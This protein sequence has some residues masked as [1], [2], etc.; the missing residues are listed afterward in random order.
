MK[1]HLMVEKKHAKKIL[2]YSHDFI[3]NYTHV[4]ISSCLHLLL[5][6]LCTELLWSFIKRAS[7]KVFHYLLARFIRRGYSRS[8]R[9]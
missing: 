8:H 4:I 6:L 2:S 1:P 9:G 5:L 7:L 3:N